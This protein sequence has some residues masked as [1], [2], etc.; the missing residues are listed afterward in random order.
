MPEVEPIVAREQ[1]Q[2]LHDE[3]Q[4]LPVVFRRPVVLCYIEGLTVERP[5]DSSGGPV[6]RFAAVWRRRTDKLRRGLTRR[7]VVLSAAATTSL[8]S[9]AREGGN[10][11]FPMRK[12]GPRRDPIRGRKGRHRGRVGLGNGSCPSGA[13]IHAAHQAEIHRAK[14]PVRRRGRHWCR[15]LESLSRDEGRTRE[16]PE[17]R[18]TAARQDPRH[19][20][21]TRSIRRR[22][23]IATPNAPGRMTVAGRVLDPDGKP[24]K[25]AAIDLVTRPRTPW[26][27]ASD[28]IDQHALLGQALSDGDGRFQLDSTRTASTT[29]FEMT[30]IAAADGYGFGWAELN[31]DAKQPAA[32]IRLQPEH[33]VPVRLVD[34]T[35]TSAR[36]VEV[37]FL[38]VTRVSDKAANNR[39]YVH[40]SPSAPAQPLATASENRRAGENHLPPDRPSR[41]DRPPRH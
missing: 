31:P 8:L 3:I 33:V 7:G 23:P 30:A 38:G 19:T 16:K 36:G 4:R 29:V 35:G 24:V 27:G 37:T 22:K 17:G 9:Q 15:F 11:I 21:K 2:A 40:P 14:L 13:E 34:L 20:L 1:A 5:R 41:N 6:A 26:V 28:E 12:H 25:G 39:I 18:N 10:L 32:D